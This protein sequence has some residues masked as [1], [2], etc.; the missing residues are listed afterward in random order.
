MKHSE[1]EQMVWTWCGWEPLQYY[2][3]L[4]GFHE[5]Q[6]G[7]ALW[8]GEWRAL[9]DSERCAAALAEAGFNWVTTRFFKGFGLEAEAEHI[10]AV[11]RMIKNYHR[12]GVR[13]FTYLQYGT[14]CPETITAEE[15]GA[16]AWP[17]QDWN[18]QHDGH[19]YEYGDQYWRAKPCANQPGFREYLLRC[20]DQ[21]VAIGADG[22]WVDNLNADGCHCACCQEAFRAWLEA[23][24]DD[25]WEAL[26]VR[27]IARLTIPRAER[28]R[29]RLFQEWT[30]WRCAETRA[31]LQQIC[32]RARERKPDV[33]MAVNTGVGNHQRALIEN[34]NWFG[35][36]DC[37][38]YTYAENG[39]FP[40]WDGTAITS[41]GATMR[42]AESIGIGIVPGAG[43]AGQRLPGPAALR[44]SF[45]ESAMFGAQAF[46]GPWGLR[47]ED[48][49]GDPLLLQDEEHR[50]QNRQL[51]EWYATHADLYRDTSDASPVA[52][53]YSYEGMVGDEADCRASFEAMMQLLQQEQIPFRTLL[54]DRMELPDGVAVL[55]LPHV[56]PLSDEHAK[57]I[58]AFVA[59]GGRVLAAGRTSLYDPHMR[60][61]RDYALADVFGHT[62][63]AAAEQQPGAL[64]LNPDNGCLHLPG[65]WGLERSRSSEVPGA[66]L[67]RLLRQMVSPDALPEVLCPAPQVGVTLRRR[68]DGTRVLGLLNYGDTPLTDIA[69][70]LPAGA[71]VRA[72]ALEH[73]GED[74]PRQT[75]P[76]RRV[77][78]TLPTLTIE[79]FVELQ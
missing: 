76:D 75:L 14:I 61:R 57:T 16:A 47:G 72:F 64:C 31:S 26:G 7:N 58:R 51:V 39:L 25:P 79:M 43:A 27:D 13:V 71:T 77:R 59:R 46:G 44:R 55:V 15:P 9:L 6:E 1:R 45:A 38:D 10:A 68:S 52:L 53:L 78:H 17:R 8:A 34:G 42:L 37:V 41:Q 22:I 49:G 2:R 69:V 32:D 4:G 56:L 3:R 74:C 33:V 63:D 62:F 50:R 28:P 36:L 54:S 73:D 5:Q 60:Q 66:R 30:S 21:A 23:N 48:G 11:E 35:H 19:P 12:H 24:I 29:D 65:A 18:G 70:V 40:R 67:A 20:V